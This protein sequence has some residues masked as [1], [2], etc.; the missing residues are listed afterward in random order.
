MEMDKDAAETL[1][2]NMLPMA[3]AKSGAVSA[4]LIQKRRVMSRSSGLSSS[5]VTVRG[6]SAMPQIGQL[7]GSART[8]SGCIGQVY[9]VRL[10][11][12]VGDSGSSAIPHF[13]QGPGPNCRTSGHIGQT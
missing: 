13:G 12:R 3:I 11:V 9:S 1:G 8:I 4:R 6:S 10:V 7:P 2:H 5:T